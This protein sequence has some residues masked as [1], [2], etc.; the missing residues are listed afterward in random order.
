MNLSSGVSALES[1]NENL[2]AENRA[3]SQSKMMN[4]FEISQLKAKN[5]KLEKERDEAIATAKELEVI[6]RGVASSIVHG[7]NHISALAEKH[8]LEAELVSGDP[9]LFLQNGSG[10][11]H[12]GTVQ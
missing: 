1:E 5:S 11:N 10:K 12:S 7:V 3:L 9:P 8:K 4:E 6:L 2:K